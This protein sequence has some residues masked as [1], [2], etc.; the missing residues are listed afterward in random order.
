MHKQPIRRPI[1]SSSLKSASFHLVPI[2]MLFALQACGSAPQLEL[3]HTE[4]LSEEFTASKTDE[5]QTLADYLQLEEALYAELDEKVYAKV[6]TGPAYKLVR[7]SSG[8][9]SDPRNNNP[10][11]NRSFVLDSANP[12]GGILLL[13][14]MSDSPYSLRALALALNQA[15]YITVGLRLPGHGTAPSGLRHVRAA[16]MIAAVRLGM[17][18]LSTQLGD[19]PVHMVGYST[20]ATLALDFTLDAMTDDALTIPASLVLISP[21]IRVHAAAALANFNDTLSN[22]PGFGRL[23]WLD[24]MPEFDPYKYNSFPTNAGDVVYRLTSSVKKR[25]AKRA[26]SNTEIVL[27][28]TLVLKSAVDSTVTTEAVVDNLLTLLKPNR[29]QLVLFDINRAAATAMLLTANPGPLNNRLLADPA[30][31]F[32]IT[33]IGNESPDSFGVV[34]SHKQA[35]SAAPTKTEPLDLEWPPYVISLSHVAVPFSPADPLYGRTPPDNR[36]TIFLG[37]M[38][39]RGER[40]LSKIPAEWLLRMRYNPFYEVVEGN[41][42]DWVNTANSSTAAK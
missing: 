41:V 22:V 40:G 3:W 33:F 32:S 14:G 15:G 27:P 21:A 28:P 25:V 7:Y 5:V 26:K 13:H 39:L 42:L 9:A 8:S 18:Y 34:A 19:K 37:E 6:D 1:H 38:A 12:R 4:K 10:N 2:A 24:V 36:D 30:L 23:G 35:F 20:G 31:P 29:H 11:W 17:D 16:D